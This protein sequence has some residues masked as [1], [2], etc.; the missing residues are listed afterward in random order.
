M[1]R[2]TIRSD[3]NAQSGTAFRGRGAK[4]T[5]ADALVTQVN[6]D[7]ATPVSIPTLRSTAGWCS[8]RDGFDVRLQRGIGILLAQVQF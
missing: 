2:D 1:I 5:I 8:S 3:Y 6:Q 4:K 7:S